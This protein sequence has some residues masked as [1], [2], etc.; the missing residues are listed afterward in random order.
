MRPTWDRLLIPF[1]GMLLAAPPALAWPVRDAAGDPL[2][3]GAIARFGTAR[4]RI[5]RCAECLQWLGP[6]EL[7]ACCSDGFVRSFAFPTGKLLRVFPPDSGR[8]AAVSPD[9]DLFAQ[10]SKDGVTVRSMHDG[11]VVSTFG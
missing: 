3:A 11:R 7:V 9:G 8:T 4:W 5:P 6:K 10:Q 1:L 2:P